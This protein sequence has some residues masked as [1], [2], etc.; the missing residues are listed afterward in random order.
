MSEGKRLIEILNDAPIGYEKLGQRFYK[1]ILENIA[2][3]LLEDGVIVPPAKVGDKVYQKGNMYSKCSAYDLTP[4]S[5][6]CTGCCAECDSKS[7]EYMYTG[8]ISYIMYDGAQF[9][10]VVH[11]ADKC[12]NSHYVIGKDIFLTENE[13]NE[14]RI[15]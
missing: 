3:Y 2:D 14:R 13:A 6:F 8:T 11:W 7:H 1:H 4:S 12:D 9:S 15:K 5:S 10:C